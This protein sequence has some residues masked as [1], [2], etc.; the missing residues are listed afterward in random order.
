MVLSTPL[1]VFTIN[2]FMTTKLRENY[3]GVGKLNVH[4][5]SL[6]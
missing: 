5:G 1:A 2:D 6:V 4:H 3:T